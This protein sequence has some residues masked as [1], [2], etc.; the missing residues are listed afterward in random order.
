MLGTL[1][2]EVADTAF[3][4]AISQTKTGF[5]ANLQLV[6]CSNSSLQYERRALLDH[7]D[8]PRSVPE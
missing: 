7:A 8:V 6:F 5:N 4:L 3:A 2:A 1:Q